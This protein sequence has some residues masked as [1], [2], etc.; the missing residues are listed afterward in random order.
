MLR[1]HDVAVLTDLLFLSGS[2]FFSRTVAFSLVLYKSYFQIVL[3][4]LKDHK[5]FY[6]G[7]FLKEA[8]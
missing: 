8:R 7:D 4:E 6:I 5:E 2:V 3:I 1:L